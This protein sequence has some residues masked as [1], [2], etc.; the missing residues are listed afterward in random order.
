VASWIAAEAGHIPYWGLSYLL[1]IGPGQLIFVLLYLFRRNL[2]PGIIAHGLSDSA[3]ALLSLIAFLPG[4]SN[5]ALAASLHRALAF[6]QEGYHAAALSELDLAERRAPNDAQ[7]YRLIGGTYQLN[8]EPGKAIVYYSKSLT[9]DPKDAGTFENRASSEYSVQDYKRALTDLDAAAALDPKSS[10][11]PSIKAYVDFAMENYDLAINDLNEAI[12]RDPKDSTLYHRR[13]Y[14]AS[15]KNDW[16]RAA[17]D[18]DRA[19][20]IDPG[21][22]QLLEQQT[23]VYTNTHDYNR[24]LTNINS[25]IKLKPEDSI[26]Y[27]ARAKVDQMLGN[28]RSALADFQQ[29]A[30]LNPSSAESLSNIATLLATSHDRQIR[31]PKQA[32]RLA[33]KA[34]DI[35]Q[36]QDAD[37]LDSLAAAYAA[38]GDYEEALR[39][40]NLAIELRQNSIST[41]VDNERQRAAAYATGKAIS[42]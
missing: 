20:K 3:P 40:Q 29:A 21:N 24:A 7:A 28:D 8:D 17:K 34:C 10:Q 12:A 4:A 30:A 31:D 32:L 42:Q 19:L 27:E 18:Y 35:T 37:G 33:R 9:L 1:F 15:Q 23:N 36:W 25:L 41:Q 11:P 22:A 2:V 6:N 26:L 39:W 16:A 14:V 5:K 13:G 38:N